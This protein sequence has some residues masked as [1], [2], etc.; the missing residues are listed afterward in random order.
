MS[1]VRWIQHLLADFLTLCLSK[2]VYEDNSARLKQDQEDIK[3]SKNIEANIGVKAI[4]LRGSCRS[5]Q[6]FLI[7]LSS[8]TL[9]DALW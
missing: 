8:S 6:S 1:P 3:S 5:I 7:S 4:S 2:G 9:Q